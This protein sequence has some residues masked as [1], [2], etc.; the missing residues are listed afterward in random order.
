[1]LLTCAFFASVLLGSAPAPAPRQ[2]GADVIASIEE[3][4][5]MTREEFMKLPAEER[6]A[7]VAAYAKQKFGGTV[8][9]PGSAAGWV[10][11]INSQKRVNSKD[12]ERPIR[13]I[14]KAAHVQWAIIEGEAAKVETALA[15]KPK[16]DANIAIYIVDDANYPALLSA[17]EE[18]WSI[19]NV[20]K[21]AADEPSAT[22]LAARLRKECS[23]GY[24]LACGAANAGRSGA[25]MGPV[26]GL[27]DL[28]MLP[29]DLLPRETLTKFE[30]Q[31]KRFGIKQIVQANYRKACEEG[32]A[33]APSDEFQKA[34]WNEVHSLPDK[35]IKITK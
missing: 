19:V 34:I 5:Q 15:L 26:S 28:D 18:G 16:Y 31:L 8:V 21:L 2:S 27:E 7:R 24:A 10:K 20:Q 30:E 25:V 3:T 9:K 32:W 17:P 4:K 33:P 12:I 29:G 14:S 13:E 1:M 6:R 35:P 22:K 23:R 11:V